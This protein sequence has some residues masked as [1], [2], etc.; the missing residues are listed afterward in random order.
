MVL[1]N[2]IIIYETLIISPGAANYV[3][4]GAN[5]TRFEHSIGWVNSLMLVLYKVFKIIGIYH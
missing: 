1:N 3:Y 4:P 2:Y 5:H